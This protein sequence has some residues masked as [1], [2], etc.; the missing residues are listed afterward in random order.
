ARGCAE[1]V[2]GW[3]GLRRC[4][5]ALAQGCRILP[6]GS[7]PAG[8]GGKL[9]R[10]SKGQ[11]SADDGL[12]GRWPVTEGAKRQLGRAPI[13]PPEAQ[14]PALAATRLNLKEQAGAAGVW[15]FPPFS[16]VRL[17]FRDLRR[18]QGLDLLLHRQML[19]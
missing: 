15:N 13:W 17:L 8:S 19:R 14:R 11:R 6:L 18:S 5:L 4:L 1:R 9:T 16:R 10:F 2:R 7:L 3:D 12:A